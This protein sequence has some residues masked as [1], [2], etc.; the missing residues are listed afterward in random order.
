MTPADAKRIL[1]LRLGEQAQRRIQELA[2]KC[3]A[4]TLTPEERTEY[5]LLV[6]AGDLVALLQ[7]KVRRYLS[8]HPE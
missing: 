5:Q 3:D 2:D 7:V 1:A 6:E 8:E 4:G